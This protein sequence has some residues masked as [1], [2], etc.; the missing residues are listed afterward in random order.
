VDE[1]AVSAFKARCLAVLREVERTRRPVRVTRYGKAVAEI[2]PPARRRAKRRLGLLAGRTE[3][4]GDIVSPA[5]PPEAWEA[6]GGRR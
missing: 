2:V 4:L 3:I 1:I 5:A 6:I